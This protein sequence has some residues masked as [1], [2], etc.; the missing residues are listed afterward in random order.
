MDNFPSIIL[1]D[2]C[3]TRQREVD[4]AVLVQ[5]LFGREL[6]AA[7]LEQ[8]RRYVAGELNREQAFAGLYS[9]R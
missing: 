1:S 8:L 3:A 6:T 5:T 4:N 2:Q 9:N 7:I